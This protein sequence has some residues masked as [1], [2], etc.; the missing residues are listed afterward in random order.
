MVNKKNQ[1]R[2]FGKAYTTVSE[3]EQRDMSNTLYLYA[4]TI[5]GIVYLKF[6]EAFKQS[7]WD[8]YNQTGCTQ[9]S[10]IRTLLYGLVTTI[11]LTP[12]KLI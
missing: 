9:H 12:Q 11:R 1:V 3:A 6:G 5:N 4:E 2:L 8:R 10:K 7:I